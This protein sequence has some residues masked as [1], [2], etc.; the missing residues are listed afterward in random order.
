[1]TDTKIWFEEELKRIWNCGE[2]EF[3]MSRGFKIT[4]YFDDDTYSIQDMRTNDFYTEV[5]EPDLMIFQEHGFLKGTSIIMYSRDVVRVKTYLE[6]IRKLYIKRKKYAAKL[7]T[8]RDFYSKR[9]RNCNEN[10]EKFNASMQFYRL[11]V[12]QFENKNKKAN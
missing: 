1:M 9:I 10:I 6:M 8:R 11:K 2:Y 12:E 5:T 7:S 3:I 4:H